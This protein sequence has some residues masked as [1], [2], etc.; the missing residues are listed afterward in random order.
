MKMKYFL[1]CLA[2]CACSGGDSDSGA[3]AGQDPCAGVTCSDHGSCVVGPDGAK[4]ECDSGYHAEGLSCVEDGTVGP[5]YGIECSGHGL[6]VDVAGSPVCQCDSDYHAEGLSCVENPVDPCLGVSC[7]SHGQCVNQDGVAACD[8]DDGYE[9]VGLEC[10]ETLCACYE[11]TKYDFSVCQYAQK[12]ASAADCCPD[13]AGIAPLVCNRDYPYRY[14]CQNGTCVAATCDTDAHCS[15]NFLDVQQDNPGL[16]VNKGCVT[17]ECAPFNRWCD[18]HK[19]CTRAAD[20]CP[21]AASIEPFVCGVDYPQ[22]YNC[23]DGICK[24]VYCT[25]DSHCQKLGEYRSPDDGWVNLG[26]VANTDPCTGELWYGLCSFKQSC[27]IYQ[28]CCPANMGELTCGADYPYLYQCRNN[29]CE[30]EYCSTDVECNAYFQILENATPGG[31][32]NQGCVDY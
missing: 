25:Q 10:Q 8:C 30:S 18:Y 13:P 11:R 23:E 15:A 26:C 24:N 6:C 27:S 28:D 32:V 5:C 21:N 12:C 9:A 14:S 2:V 1:M 20:C 29:L 4:C 31:Y 22:I 16:W 17:S 19:T 3:D 7:S